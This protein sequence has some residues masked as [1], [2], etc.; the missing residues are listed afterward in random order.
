MNLILLPDQLI[1][2]TDCLM[3]WLQHIKLQKKLC[4]EKNVK[5]TMHH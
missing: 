1:I 2:V 4:A 3:C 5:C